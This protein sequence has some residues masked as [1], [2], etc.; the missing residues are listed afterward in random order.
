[1]EE[2]KIKYTLTYV[3]SKE[4]YDH[5]ETLK[6]RVSYLDERIELRNNSFDRRERKALRHCL[7]LLTLELQDDIMLTHEKAREA[8]RS[9]DSELASNKRIL[10]VE[11]PNTPSRIIL[12]KVH[13]GEG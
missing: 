7:W 4:V 11:E 13:K 10:R 1:M 9:G 6:R 12:R 5:I 2:R 3:D 8:H